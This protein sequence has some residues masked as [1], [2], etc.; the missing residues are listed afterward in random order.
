MTSGCSGPLSPGVAAS[1]HHLVKPALSK[2]EQTWM[3]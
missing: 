1:V 3:G 2:C